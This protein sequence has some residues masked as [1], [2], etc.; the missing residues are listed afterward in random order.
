LAGIGSEQFT[1]A[2]QNQLG[3]S[4]NPN[5]S[6]QFTGPDLRTFS[7][8]WS[9]YPRTKVESENIDYMIRQLKASALPSH[10]ITDSTAI[11]NYPD[12]VQINFFPWD[13]GGADNQWGWTDRSI[14]RIKKCFMTNVRVSYSEFGNPAFFEGTKLPVAYRLNISFQETEYMLSENW[15][16]NEWSKSKNGDEVLSSVRETIDDKINRALPELNSS[17][18]ENASLGLLGAE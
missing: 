18:L 5:P 13:S 11:L 12:L 3:I 9:F 7:L 1:S 14:L 15:G 2:L 4:P 8:S 6:V 10:T 17:I 16:G